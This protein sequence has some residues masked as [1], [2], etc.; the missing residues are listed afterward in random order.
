[1]SDRHQEESLLSSWADGQQKVLEDWLDLMHGME[2]PSRSATWNETMKAWQVAVQETLETQA[3]WLRGWNGRIQVT[4]GSP[5]DLR[6]NVQQ[7]QVLLLRWTEAQ[8]HL[9][10][11]WFHLVQHLGPL[12]ETGFQIDE[13]LLSRLQERGQAMINAHTEWV[14]L[15]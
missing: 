11:D 1:M 6:K 14:R 3:R 2:R 12:L 8:Q 13:H 4:S 7:A 10:Q 9:W 5:T 15:W